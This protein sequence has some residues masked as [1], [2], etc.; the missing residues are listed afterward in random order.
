MLAVGVLMAFAA[1]P[2]SQVMAQG[3]MNSP[4][5]SSSSSGNETLSGKTS[6][7]WI[8]TKVKSEL[9][10]AKNV[11]STDIS[12]TTTEGVVALTGTVASARVKAHVIHVVRKVKGVKD[13]DADGLTITPAGY[14]S[15][16]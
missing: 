1:L 9:M 13:V 2:V 15:G 11:K 14:D 3:A 8:T 12:V 6:D 10:D 16:Q 5:A 4:Q 7:T